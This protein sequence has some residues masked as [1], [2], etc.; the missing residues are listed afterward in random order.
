MKEIWKA[1]VGLEGR[2]EVS[3]RGR[4]RSVPRRLHI[5]ASWRR[6]AHWR[7]YRGKLL[8]PGRYTSSGHVAVVLGHGAHGSP[9][10]LLVLAAF[11]GPLPP[12]KETRHLNGVA[13]DNRLENLCYGT[14]S[15]N[16]KDA[17]AHGARA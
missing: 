17:W 12:G 2:Y 14:R 16:M 11:I 4:V 8:R 15:E 10:H 7:S 9:V 1:V 3:D 6:P 13:D 5:R